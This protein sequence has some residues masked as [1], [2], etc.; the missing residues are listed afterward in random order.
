[1]PT[2]PCAIEAAIPAQ[3]ELDVVQ[4]QP[5]C[6]A[7]AASFHSSAQAPHAAPERQV[8][9]LLLHSSAASRQQLHSHRP[10]AACYHSGPPA[11]ALPRPLLRRSRRQLDKQCCHGWQR[12]GRQHHGWIENGYRHRDC[13]SAASS[14]DRGAVMRAPSERLHGAPPA[15]LHSVDVW[16]AGYSAID[17]RV[18]GTDMCIHQGAGVSFSACVYVFT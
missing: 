13:S 18:S 2:Q 1:M 6:G 10:R 11:A 9:Q 7:G 3:P 17:V 14:G 5:W 15:C 8:P 16:Q 12:R 4:K